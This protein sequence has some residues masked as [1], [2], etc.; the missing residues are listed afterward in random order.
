MK[1][2]EDHKTCVIQDFEVVVNYFKGTILVL[3]LTIHKK[4]PSIVTVCLS[5][6]FGPGLSHLKHDAH[7]SW[8]LLVEADI[9]TSSLTSQ[10]S[11]M[12]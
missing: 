5:A 6:E 11:S 7:N 1:F 4:N 10:I 3:S 12:M 9:S 2:K 8:M